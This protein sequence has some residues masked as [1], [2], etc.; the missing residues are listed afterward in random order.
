MELAR[1]HLYIEGRVQ[2]VFYRAFTRDIAVS[3]GLNG[4]VMNLRDGRVEAL[5]EGEKDK[6]EKAIR[7]C[8]KGP[9]GARVTNIEVQW[10]PYK[11]DQ[12]DF[13]VKYNR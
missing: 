1:A 12:K 11:G 3:F 13:F 5:F 10:E 6:I 4:W 7:E 9:P 8:Y 2:G